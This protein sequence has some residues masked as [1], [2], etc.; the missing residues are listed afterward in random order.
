MRE[1][2]AFVCDRR[3]RQIYAVSPVVEMRPVIALVLGG[4]HGG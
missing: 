1:E 3:I 4:K 2:E